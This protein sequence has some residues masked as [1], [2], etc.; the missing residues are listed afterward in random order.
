MYSLSI[1][2]VPDSIPPIALYVFIQELQFLIVTNHLMMEAE[3]TLETSSTFIK[4]TS[5]KV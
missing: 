4:Y 1:Q 2:E 3:S 5:D